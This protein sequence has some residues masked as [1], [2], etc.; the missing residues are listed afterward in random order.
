MKRNRL[1]GSAIVMVLM[2]VLLIAGSLFASSFF[3]GLETRAARSGTTALRAWLAARSAVSLALGEIEALA[4]AGGLPEAG[5]LGPWADG[6]PAVSYQVQEAPDAG[7]GPALLY[8]TLHASATVEAATAAEHLVVSVAD[9][10][11]VAVWSRV[12]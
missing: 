1:G 6:S 2:V 5:S 8:V 9:G 4:E 11:L 10:Q 7:G 12:R 3:V